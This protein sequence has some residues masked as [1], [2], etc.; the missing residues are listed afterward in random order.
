MIFT[1]NDDADIHPAALVT[2]KEYVPEARPETVVFVPDPVVVTSPGLR[3]NIQLPDDGNELNAT[4]PVATEQVGWLMVPITGA[5]GVT[6]CGIISAPADDGDVQPSALV[7]VKVYV[8]EAIPEIV[9]PVPFP[10]VVIPPGVRVIVQSP[11]DGNP[12][13]ATLPVAT[14]HV[15]WVIA[16]K[17]G[18]VGVAGWTGISILSESAETHPAALVTV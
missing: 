3:V 1:F 5:F 18:T 15:G 4:L 9:V 14:E 13:N 8:P 16:P 17:T 11:V 2:V 7:T 10:V 6:G 12:V